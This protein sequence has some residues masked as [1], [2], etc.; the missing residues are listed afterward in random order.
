MRRGQRKAAPHS[1]LQ[2]ANS[3]DRKAQAHLYDYA[4]AA[5]NLDSYGGVIGR[6]IMKKLLFAFAAALILIT[7]LANPAPAQ[8]WPQRTIR[9]VV[10]F[11]P[12]G[13]A[14][15]IGRILADSMQSK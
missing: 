8:E 3:R 12:G 11:G 14:D 13:G 15:I 5:R 1:S 6:I 10:S 2:S 4:A 9:I 7:E